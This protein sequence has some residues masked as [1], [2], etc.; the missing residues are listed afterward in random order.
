MIQAKP[1]CLIHRDYDLAPVGLFAPL[2]SAQ[3]NLLLFLRSR[4]PF[5]FD[6]SLGWSGN[7]LPLRG[8]FTLSLQRNYPDRPRK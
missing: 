6:S 7:E 1:M 2:H 4:M 5:S 3:L 8:G